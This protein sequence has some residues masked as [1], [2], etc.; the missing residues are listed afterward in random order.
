MACVAQCM[1]TFR[2]N[3]IL[4]ILCLTDYASCHGLHCYHLSVMWSLW[5][6]QWHH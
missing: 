6:N 1:A 3:C 5:R 2:S 4:Y